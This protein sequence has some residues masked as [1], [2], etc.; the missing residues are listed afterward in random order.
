MQDLPT[1]VD[2]VRLHNFVGEGLDPS[3]ESS[4]ALWHEIMQA[5]HGRGGS[6]DTIANL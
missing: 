1:G 5:T 6:P 3:I 2:N 4:N